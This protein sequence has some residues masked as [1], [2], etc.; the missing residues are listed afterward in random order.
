MLCYLYGKHKEKKDEKARNQNDIQLTE[1][2]LDANTKK[3]FP[4]GPSSMGAMN[5]NDPPSK[6]ELEKF[7]HLPKTERPSLLLQT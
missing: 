4:N 6:F 7:A 3:D 5:I 1:V 2:D